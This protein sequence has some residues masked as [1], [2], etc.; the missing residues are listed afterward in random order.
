MRPTPLSA[1]DAHCPSAELS[2]MDGESEGL[3]FIIFNLY[4]EYE[5]VTFL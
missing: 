1:K 2:Q 3:S 4:F 5:Y